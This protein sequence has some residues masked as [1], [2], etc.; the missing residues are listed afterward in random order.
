MIK[1]LEYAESI[2]RSNPMNAYD[3]ATSDEYRLPDNMEVYLDALYIE[4]KALWLMSR[5][6]EAVKRADYLIELS[7]M[8]KSDIGQGRGHNVIGNVYHDMSNLDK[9]LEHYMK[10]LNFSRK[11]NDKKNEAALLNNI[12]EIY[13]RLEDYHEALEYYKKSMVLSKDVGELT[14]YGVSQLNIGE[15]NYEQGYIDKAFKC[16]KDALNHFIHNEDYFSIAYG[17]FLLSKIYRKQ[18]YEDQ[19]KSDLS[20]AIDIM[21]RLQDHYNLNLAYLEMIDIL[22]GE[23]KFEEAL[24][25]IE[26][27]LDI[28]ERLNLNKDTADIALYAAEIYEK[29]KQFD[30]ALDA[31]KMYVE[32]RFKYEKEK[33]E[34]HL[35]NIKAQ[36]NIE[37]TMHEK[38]IYRLRN[39]ELKK[40]TQEIEKLYNDMKIITNIGQN[41][42]STLDTKKI[43]HLLYDNLGKLMDAHTFGV[44][45][46]DEKNKIIERNLLLYK[47]KDLTR[48]P[49]SID[50]KTSMSAW[51]I[52]NKSPLMVNDVLQLPKTIASTRERIDNHDPKVKAAIFVPLIMQDNVIGCIVVKSIYKDAY[53]EYQFNLIK[54]L[55]SYITI[56]VINS[57]ESQMLSEEIERRITVQKSLEE[58]NEK[59]SEMSYKDA[60]TNIPNRRSFVEFFSR[61]LARSARSKEVLT[62]LII[63]I[64]HFKEYNDNYGHVKGDA[65]LT[66]VAKILKNT[67]KRE[68]DFVARY[69]GDEFV[70]VLSDTNLQGSKQIADSIADNVKS[71]NIEHIYSPI[72]DRVSLT[73]GGIVLIPD[74]DAVMET[75]ISQADT[76]LYKAKDLGRNQICIEKG[77]NLND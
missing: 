57:Q 50:S 44:Y 46:Y 55:A 25:Y 19:A 49:V 42:T 16:T 77:S 74:E 23:D 43:I 5:F 29:T 68:I 31:Y 32:A 67:L 9:S 26:D 38:E 41:I 70:V 60:L 7:Q 35:K 58:L 1:P 27:A 64:D 11:V 72:A 69:G 2:L 76:A 15:L 21:R 4:V 28:S 48:P 53:H 40:K 17:H 61:E 20:L 65:C 36:I 24:E 13:R 56:A 63:D 47:G 12:G 14:L 8:E 22:A 51:V 75:I 66:Q 54:A 34:E 52:R 33:E 73:I 59:L 37:N 45:L 30:L 10:G 6:E 3:I 62:L 39:V 71:E 18:G